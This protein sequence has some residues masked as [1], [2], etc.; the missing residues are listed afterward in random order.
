MTSRERLRESQRGGQR[1]RGVHAVDE[2]RADLS[3][4]HPLDQLEHRFLGAGGLA[5]RMRS[6]HRHALVSENAVE[7]PGR[8]LERHRLLRGRRLRPGHDEALAPRGPELV[9]EPRDGPEREPRAPL[10]RRRLERADHRGSATRRRGAAR[11]RHEELVRDGHRHRIEVIR[12]DAKPLVGVGP[13][14]RGDGLDRD[15]AHHR[16]HLGTPPSVEV[17]RVLDRRDHRPERIRSERDEEIGLVEAVARHGARSV[18]ELLRLQERV[19]RHRVV[20]DVLGVG[21]GREELL[22]ER[23]RR[24]ARHRAGEEHDLAAAASLAERLRHLLIDR[25]PGRGLVGALAAPIEERPL[26]P[27]GIVEI[28]E[29]G[30][31]ARAEGPLVERVGLVPLELD[32]APLARLHEH[33]APRGAIAAGGCVVDGHAGNQ[34]FGR[35]HVREDLLDRLP[36]ASGRGERRAGAEELQEFAARG[37]IGRIER[38]RVRR[39]RELLHRVLGQ[40][41]GLE[42]HGPR[43]VL[44]RLRSAVYM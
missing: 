34:L 1:V 29:R 8:H 36:R 3:G 5:R 19:L 35:V 30:L 17:A 6:V 10:H 9:R 28:E 25:L 21:I 13:G 22:H 38:D 41:R 26:E 33:A 31:A 2:E 40:R 37:R 42:I 15:H 12:T 20:H 43:P 44:G 27:V 39:L 4:A 18:H 14:E 32:R 24:R 23:H 16:A 11:L 7:E